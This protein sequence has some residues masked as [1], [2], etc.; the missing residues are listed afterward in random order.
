MSHVVDIIEWMLIFL[1][2]KMTIYQ[3]RESPYFYVLHTEV[4]YFAQLLDGYWKAKR[5]DI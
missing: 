4:V 1:S 3:V 5:L 2:V